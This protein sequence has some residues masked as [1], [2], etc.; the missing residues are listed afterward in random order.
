M[1]SDV[2]NQKTK[3]ATFTYSRKTTRKITKLFKETQI[4]IAYRT[5][6]IIE[7]ILKLH[8]KIGKYEKSDVHAMKC[9]DCPLKYVSHTGRIFR[10]RYKEHIPAIRSNNSNSGYSHHI[11]NTGHAYGTITDIMDIVK[12]AKG[13]GGNIQIH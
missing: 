3:W 7:N 13:G 1:F 8:P 2:V 10:T 5:L 11:L 9:Q 4:K 12:I 6:N